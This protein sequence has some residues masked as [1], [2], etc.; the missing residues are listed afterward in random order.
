MIQKVL[1]A[2]EKEPI[3]FILEKV[4]TRKGYR[5]IS[6]ANGLQAVAMAHDEKPDILLFTLNLPLLSGVEA[7][8]KIYSITINEKRPPSILLVTKEEEEIAKKVCEE[9]GIFAYLT[10]PVKPKEL[11]ELVADALRS[12]RYEALTS[13]SEEA[14]TEEDARSLLAAYRQSV[15]KLFNRIKKKE[16]YNYSDTIACIPPLIK[17]IKKQKISLIDIAG[18]EKLYRSIHVVNVTILSMQL[19]YACGMDD[20]ELLELGSSALFMEAGHMKATDTE[21]PPQL[22][23]SP[24]PKEMEPLT[25]HIDAGVI[26]AEEEGMSGK[27]IEAISTH[28]ER[29][30]G[31]GYPN[32]LQGTEIP[33]YARILAV[34]DSIDYLT[35]EFG[36]RKALSIPEAIA[37]LNILSNR[38]DPLILR[39][40]VQLRI[41][42]TA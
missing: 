9:L 5:A 25:E 31:S 10:Q 20:I 12:S 34:A 8:K 33:T 41:K 30:D 24:N 32:R 21:C 28:H 27:V 29:A 1:I 22:E 11:I 17:A 40:L 2:E 14:V 6:V 13:E 42:K 19:G 18:V 7:V 36:Q 35:T 3:R 4:L 37:Q 39:K 16:T 15:G 26:I 38:Y 23:M